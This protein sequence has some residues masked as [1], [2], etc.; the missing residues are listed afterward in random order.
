MPPR[1]YV[2]IIFREGRISAAKTLHNVVYVLSSLSFVSTFQLSSDFAIF[3][4]ATGVKFMD[5][6][7]SGS[8]FYRANLKDA[9][10]SRASLLGTRYVSFLLI[11]YY[12]IYSL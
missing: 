1:I 3:V 5:S 4:D 12:R 11:V 9:D 2:R 8:R 6:V 7:L 10:F